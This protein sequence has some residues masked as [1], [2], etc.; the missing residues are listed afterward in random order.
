ML[1]LRLAFTHRSAFLAAVGERA[2]PLHAGQRSAFF[3]CTEY[4]QTMHTPFYSRGLELCG[5]SVQKH[6]SGVNIS[7]DPEL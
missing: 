2:P 3:S 1:K 7:L 5:F 4:T 6:R